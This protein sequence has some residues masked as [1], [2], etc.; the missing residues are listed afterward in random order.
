MQDDALP[1]SLLTAR[2]VA[3]LLRVSGA[4]EVPTQEDTMP[5]CLLT[6]REVAELLRVS[7]KTVLRLLRQGALKGFSRGRL[8]R[9]EVESLREWLASGRVHGAEAAHRL[10]GRPR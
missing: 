5:S 9:I 6:A 7:R 3:E 4:T 8:T 1:S 10:P 2:E